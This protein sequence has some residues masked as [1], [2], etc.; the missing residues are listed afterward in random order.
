MGFGKG[1]QD[2]A[3]DPPCGV[4][5]CLGRVTHGGVLSSRIAAGFNPRQ[6]NRPVHCIQIHDVVAKI[7][8]PCLLFLLLRYPQDFLSCRTL[9]TIVLTI[10]VKIVAC[11][12]IGFLM[13]S[14][15]ETHSVGEQAQQ[16][17]THGAQ[18]RQ[19][20]GKDRGKVLGFSSQ[21]TLLESSICQLSAIYT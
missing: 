19:A 1:A 15:F 13:I 16:R 8:E 3:D 11:R 6:Y 5:H 4:H 20:L 9:H 17:H 14:L 21:A 2:D 7:R 10:L 18:R 12:D